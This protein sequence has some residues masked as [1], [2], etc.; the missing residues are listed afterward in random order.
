MKD[1]EAKRKMDVFRYK[2]KTHHHQPRQPFRQTPFRQGPSQRGGGHTSST[3]FVYRKGQQG[4]G[5]QNKGQF[6]TKRPSPQQFGI[7]CT[8]TRFGPKKCPSSNKKYFPRI[9][10]PA[11]STSGKVKELPE[12][13]GKTYERSG[14]FVY[15]QRI[16]NT[17][18][19]KP[20]TKF[21]KKCSNEERTKG[22]SGQ[23]SFR[24]VEE[25]GNKIVS[26]PTKPVSKYSVLSREKGRRVS[27]SDK[28]KTVKQVYTL[29]TF[30]NG[31]FALPE[32]HAKRGGL[33]VQARY[34]RCI[35]F[36][37]SESDI[38]RESA[39]SVVR[40]IILA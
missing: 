27:P 9:C 30:Q 32:I 38:Q 31:R 7:S 14:N 33:H 34:E 40:E 3:R 20:N 29:P 37:S 17:F 1:K 2:P 19:N 6:E 16:S 39:F 4:Q 18:H 21:S 26:K 12:S 8:S 23:G 10:N 24:H 36:S 15:N 28:S 5:N 11:I 35:L 22:T 13:M 25:R